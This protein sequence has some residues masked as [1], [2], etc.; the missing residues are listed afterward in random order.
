MTF[1]LQADSVLRVDDRGAIRV[2]GTRVLLDLIVAAFNAGQS[3]ETIADEYPSLTL[4]DVYA[5]VA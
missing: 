3:P 4:A 5:A 1:A 2:G